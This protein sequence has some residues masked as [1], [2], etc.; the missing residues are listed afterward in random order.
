MYLHNK[1]GA[2]C[3]MP[4]RFSRLQFR[5]QY[6]HLPDMETFR[7]GLPTDTQDFRW[8]SGTLWHDGPDLVGHTP[9]LLCPSSYR[10]V[11]RGPEGEQPGWHMLLLYPH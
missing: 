8:D 11:A 10:F 6:F 7:G 1:Q 4:T 2:H 3:Q 5:L 9:L